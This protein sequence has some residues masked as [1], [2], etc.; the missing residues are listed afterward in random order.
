MNMNIIQSRIFSNPTHLYHS[1]LTRQIDKVLNNLNII[2]I[3]QIKKITEISSQP[4]YCQN[5]NDQ[6]VVEICVTRVTSCVRETG[7]VES[8]CAALVGL[9]EACLHHNL[10]P[11]SHRDEDQPHAK[12]ASDVISCIFLVREP[13]PC[14][15]NLSY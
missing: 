6:S 11:T 4:D 12:I 9:L 13:L 15:F 14:T 10:R 7:S 2:I 5:D 1:V 3:L 8:H